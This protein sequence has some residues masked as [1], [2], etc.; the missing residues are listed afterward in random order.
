MLTNLKSPI[1]VGLD[2]TLTCMDVT[3]CLSMYIY[4]IFY[5]LFI[6]FPFESVMQSWLHLLY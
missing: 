5:F 3:F 4:I 6:L 1:H 2:R